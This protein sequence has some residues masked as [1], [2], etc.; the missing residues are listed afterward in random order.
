MFESLPLSFT[1]SASLISAPLYMLHRGIFYPHN[2]ELFPARPRTSIHPFRRPYAC[3]AWLPLFR[4]HIT[5]LPAS[6]PG[7]TAVLFISCFRARSYFLLQFQSCFLA[8]ACDLY[9]YYVSCSHTTSSSF[10]LT[11]SFRYFL[12]SFNV[13]VHFSF[14]AFMTA[15]PS[16]SSSSSSPPP[17]LNS[18]L[19]ILLHSRLHPSFHSHCS[20]F[21]HYFFLF[22]LFFFPPC[23]VFFFSVRFAVKS[24]LRWWFIF[25]YSCYVSGSY[26]AFPCFPFSFLVL[27]SHLHFL[28][29]PSFCCLYPHATSLFLPSLPSF[30]YSHLLFLFHLI[31][32]S[33]FHLTCLPFF[34]P[35]LRPLFPF[36]ILSIFYSY[37]Y[38]PLSSSIF[39]LSLT[40]NLPFLIFCL[41]P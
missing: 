17:S 5:F 22:S 10:S 1:P 32:S 28:S 34:T 26:I 8:S 35:P 29:I 3:T 39:L 4:M 11:A 24:C 37:F 6:L 13:F 38:T 31:F 20:I 25:L 2:Q 40:Q 21:S 23:K 15:L 27:F 33:S 16:W 19:Y 41:S 12:I 14:F 9:F 7:F 18:F 36:C 30:L